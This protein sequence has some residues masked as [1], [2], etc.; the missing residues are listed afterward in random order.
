MAYRELHVVEV[1]EVLR[2]WSR[3]RGFRTVAQR[4]GV[5][6]KT[7]RR[8]VE[9][10]KKAGLVRG[11]QVMWDFSTRYVL[12]VMALDTREIVHFAV[13]RSPT[14]GCVEQQLREATPWGEVPWFLLH[15]NDGIFGQYPRAGVEFSRKYR[16]ALDAWLHRV[17]GIR[18]IPIPYGAPN[19]QAHVERFIGTLRRECL[20]HFIFL[21]DGN[22]R[23]TLAEFVSYYNGFRPHQGLMGIPASQEQFGQVEHTSLG[24]RRAHLI[25]RPILGGLHHDYSLAA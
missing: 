3:G 11:T 19:A 22:L 15:D 4:T 23:R 9:A 21:S 16:C 5:N 14:L 10:A 7:V 17:L 6:R 2:L 13:T 8:Y 18:E 12:I 25:S 20:D 24:G 1:K